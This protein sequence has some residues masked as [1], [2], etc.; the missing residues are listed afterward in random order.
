VASVLESSVIV[1][2]AADCA[3][4]DADRV[5]D[6]GTAVGNA[7]T[8]AAGAGDTGLTGLCTFTV[9]EFG[10]WDAEFTPALVLV[11]SWLLLVDEGSNV[12]PAMLTSPSPQSSSW[13]LI[14]ANRNEH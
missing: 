2:R 6:T 14:Q 4:L 5:D 9:D 7:A 12:E 8:A 13:Q 1:S 11:L 10:A 3:R